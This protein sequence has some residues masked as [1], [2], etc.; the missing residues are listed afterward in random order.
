MHTKYKIFPR[1]T[2]VKV[3]RSGEV[4]VFLGYERLACPPCPPEELRESIRYRLLVDGYLSEYVD[5]EIEEVAS[6]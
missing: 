5:M 1:G 4:G 6:S 2:L 3:R